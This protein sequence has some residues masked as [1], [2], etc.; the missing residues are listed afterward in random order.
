VLV[1]EDNAVNMELVTALLES[2]GCDVVPAETAIEGIR[3]AVEVQPDLILMDVQLP[4]M[5]GYDATRRLKGEAVTAHIPVVAFTAHAMRGEEERARAAGC[6]SYLTKPVDAQR[7][8]EIIRHFLYPSVD[9]ADAA[10]VA[11][12]NG[13]GER[14]GS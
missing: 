4:V 8:R 3:L 5:T 12:T 7:F 2:E 1:V 9:G 11:R 13:A 14:D 6:D 10:R